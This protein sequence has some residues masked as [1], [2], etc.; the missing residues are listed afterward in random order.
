MLLF[1]LKFKGALQLFC[2]MK[3]LKKLDAKVSWLSVPVG[4]VLNSATW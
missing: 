4:N 3:K 1:D 2:K